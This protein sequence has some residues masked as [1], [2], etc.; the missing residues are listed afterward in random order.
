MSFEKLWL[1]SS[2][3]EIAIKR[4]LEVV[5]ARGK[6][7]PV[8]VI[9]VTGQI[10][11]V[12]FSPLDTSPWTLSPITIPTQQS[13]YIYWPT[14]VGDT[15]VA[16]AADAYIGGIS[17]LG[18]PT[19]TLLR[20]HGNLSTLYFVPI[21]TKAFA[22][23]NP[24]A[25]QIQGPDG[26]ILRTTTGTTSSVVTDQNGTTVTYGANT[27][28]INGSEISLTV[29]TSTVTV[30]SSEI[31][32]TAGGYPIVINSSGLS[33]NGSLFMAHEHSGVTTGTGNTGG[34]T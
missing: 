19:G 6:S 10:V 17:G 26:V 3:N 28:V 33:I 11:T 15:G 5:H 30:N 8:R 16:A 4:A 12:D 21:G 34:V 14:Q 20:K 9:A 13:P 7:L 24:N 32:L 31:S 23:I 27:I 22:P 29:G 2:L 25:A 1:Q 18:A